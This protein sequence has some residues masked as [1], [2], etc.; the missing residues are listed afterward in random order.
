MGEEDSS[1][2][3]LEAF[4]P[5]LTIG[6]LSATLPPAGLSP[7]PGWPLFPSEAWL[8]WPLWEPPPAPE[9]L[10]PP[11]PPASGLFEMPA[12]APLPPEW[13][14]PPPPGPEPCSFGGVGTSDS[15]WIP[16]ASSACARA[17]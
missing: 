16:V 13:L 8:L 14:V 10:P 17:G 3:A 7:L 9:P 5:R 6:L 2:A 1:S 15:Y 11:E 4:S 12:P